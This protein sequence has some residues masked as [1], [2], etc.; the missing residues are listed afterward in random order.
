MYSWPVFVYENASY[1][2][3]EFPKIKI[4][5]LG[6]LGSNRNDIRRITLSLT[7]YCRSPRMV[8]VESGTLPLAKQLLPYKFTNNIIYL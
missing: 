4:Y 6:I 8:P 1:I 5:T 7:L 2:D 3:S